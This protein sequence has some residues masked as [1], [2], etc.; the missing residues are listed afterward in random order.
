V[1]TKVGSARRRE[2]MPLQRANVTRILAI[3]A[4]YAR[5]R[6]HANDSGAA[7]R[8]APTK[9]CNASTRTMHST[10]CARVVGSPLQAELLAA[11]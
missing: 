9:K 10:I 3:S 6:R 5:G 4:G 1:S 2:A 7:T 11:P 8:A